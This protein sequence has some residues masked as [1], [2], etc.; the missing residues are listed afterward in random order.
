[1]TQNKAQKNVKTRLPGGYQ[2]PPFGIQQSLAATIVCV[3]LWMLGMFW[4]G[5]QATE[6]WIGS[7][8]DDIR[9]HVYLE[10]EQKD[11]LKPLMA[12]LKEV[13]GVDSIRLVQQEETEAWLSKWLG[14]SG[15]TTKEMAEVLP[16]VIEVL[17]ERNI[18]EFLFTDIKDE[19]ALLGASVNEEE[20]YF[21]TAQSLFDDMRLFLWIMSALIA[22][23]MMVIIS[24]TLR[25]II[26]A[27]ADE[28]HLMRLLGAQE[29][30]VRMPF[31]LEGALIGLLSGTLAWFMDWCVL[32]LMATWLSEL[33]L[34]MNS[35]YL[36]PVMAGGG[37]LIGFTGAV[38]ATSDVKQETASIL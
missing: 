4:L 1:M 30:F 34:D 28:I 37:V 17:P 35:W 18:H 2:L 24:N 6:Q 9:F 36:L 26:L 3:A 16:S 20:S 29:W 11:Q 14:D 33:Q 32:Q 22:L 10:H 8:Q 7:W 21:A 27:R 25:M 31:L 19:A 23:A 38:I 5:L 12:K 13:P 15:L